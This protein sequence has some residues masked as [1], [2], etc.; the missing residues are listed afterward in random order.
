MQF[1]VVMTQ[2]EKGD[3]VSNKKIIGLIN[4]KNIK[5]RYIL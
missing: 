1:V 5:F 3:C 4:F 2:R